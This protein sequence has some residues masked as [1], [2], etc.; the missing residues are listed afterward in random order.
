MR[1]AGDAKLAEYLFLRKMLPVVRATWCGNIIQSLLQ[2]G[3][4]T[5]YESDTQ[6]DSLVRWR[7]ALNDEAIRYGRLRLPDDHA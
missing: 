5:L 4:I 7:G 1:Q 6:R 3:H 2:T